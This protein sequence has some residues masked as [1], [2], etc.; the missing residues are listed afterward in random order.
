M[1]RRAALVPALAL[2][3]LI[4]ACQQSSSS[5]TPAGDSSA[6]GV[7]V[8]VNYSMAPGRGGALYIEG[9]LPQMTLRGDGYHVMRASHSLA[10]STLAF[11]DVRPGT[12]RLDAGV[13]PCDGNCGYLDALTDTC[14]AQVHV[15]DAPVTLTVRW[16]VGEPCQIVAGN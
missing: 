10:R 6:S 4:T 11:P 15:T 2:L 14:S 9:A 16:R 8:T 1:G 13:R 3:G 7:T 12:Y 5:G